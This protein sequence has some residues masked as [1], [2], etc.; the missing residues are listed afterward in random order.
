MRF[1]V[2]FFLFYEISCFLVSNCSFAQCNKTEPFI[3]AQ[4][5]QWI[6]LVSPSGCPTEEYARSSIVVGRPDDDINHPSV[7][8]FNSKWK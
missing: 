2:C 5:R 6:Q 4:P 7:M 1:I 3:C 8:Y